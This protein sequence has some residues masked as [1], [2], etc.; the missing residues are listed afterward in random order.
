MKI[1]LAGT[2]AMGVI[3]MKALKKID[4]A[5]ASAS[6]TVGAT[7]IFTGKFKS[8]VMRFTIAAC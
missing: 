2:G 7:I 5:E 3:H 4:D 1:C 8:R 6:R